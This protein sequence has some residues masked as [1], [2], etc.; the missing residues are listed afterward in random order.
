MTVLLGLGFLLK[1]S[2][3]RL[4]ERGSVTSLGLVC[5]RL[6]DRGGASRSRGLSFLQSVW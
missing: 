4:R 5:E 1:S 6:L 3:T 2:M